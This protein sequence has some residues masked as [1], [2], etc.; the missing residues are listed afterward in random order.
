LRS[1]DY[2]C[3]PPCLAL[4]LL[5][6]QKYVLAEMS[7]RLY[8]EKLNNVRFTLFHSILFNH[9]TSLGLSFLTFSDNIDILFSLDEIMCVRALYKL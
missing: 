8:V 4:D 3:V 9:L 5:L 1:W 7:I 2:K 6:S